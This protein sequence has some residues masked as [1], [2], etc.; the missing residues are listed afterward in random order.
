MSVYVYAPV[1]GEPAVLGEIRCPELPAVAVFVTESKA[2]AR[3]WERDLRSGKLPRITA[4]APP[5]SASGDEP[6]GVSPV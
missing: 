6:A 1:R 4:E 5:W 2:T 3:S